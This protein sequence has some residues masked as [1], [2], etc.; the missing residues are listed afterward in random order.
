MPDSGE[1]KFDAQVAEAFDAIA[2][3]EIPDYL[4]VIELCIRII[5]QDPRA[6]PKIIDVGSATGETLR[7]LHQAGYRQL[8][9]VDASADM[10]ARSFSEATLIHSESFPETYGPFD[11]VLNNWTLHFIREPEAYLAAIKRSLAPGGTLVLTNKVSCSERTH[12]LYHNYKRSHGVNEQAIAKKQA[13]LQGVLVTQPLE[14]HLQLLHQLGFAQVEVVNAH[15]A[16]VTLSATNP[17]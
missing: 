15:T 2:Q 1:W 10:L 6:Q 8:F 13:Q 4:R 9:G 3:R 11:Y 5:R 17:A 7:Q 14:W 16:F 12:A